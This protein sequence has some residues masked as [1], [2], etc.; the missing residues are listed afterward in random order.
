[1]NIMMSWNYNRIKASL[2]TTYNDN[3]IYAELAVYFQ[4]K[5]KVESLEQQL[6]SSEDRCSQ[7]ESEVKEVNN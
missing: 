4:M 5:L 2:R 7:L 3:M 1:M 6:Q